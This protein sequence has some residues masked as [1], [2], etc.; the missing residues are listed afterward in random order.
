MLRATSPAA[1]HA[2]MLIS[3]PP[4]RA[5]LLPRQ[6]I[7]LIIADADVDYDFYAY[8]TPHYVMLIF[9]DTAAYCHTWRFH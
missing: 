6:I 4:C 5:L 1:R 9:A 3:S 8:A 2:A 7:L